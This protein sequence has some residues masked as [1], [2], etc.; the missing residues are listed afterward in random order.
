[1]I[2]IGLSMARESRNDILEEV[3]R[4]VNGGRNGAEA[5][6]RA[7]KRSAGDGPASAPRGESIGESPPRSRV[8]SQGSVD[9]EDR[10]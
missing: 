1:M 9:A 5:G 2:R 8:G 3:R 4:I 7:H 6:G 10:D